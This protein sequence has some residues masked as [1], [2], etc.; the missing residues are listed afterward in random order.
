MAKWKPSVVFLR[1]PGFLASLRTV[2]IRLRRPPARPIEDC[3][4]RNQVDVMWD[5]AAFPVWGRPGATF[6][7]DRALDAQLRN[8][9]QDWSDRVTQAVA[10]P[11]GPDMPG[12]EGPTDQVV[13]GV[14][15]R[16]AGFDSPPSRRI[17]TRRNRRV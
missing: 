16:G 1:G 17:R 15:H 2:R 3:A 12:R 9:L 10:G 6:D 7:L 13:E 14:Q 4:D 8:D 11:N 5:Y